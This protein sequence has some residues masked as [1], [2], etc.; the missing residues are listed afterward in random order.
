[1]KSDLGDE[2]NK[3]RRIDTLNQFVDNTNF[4]IEN[5]LKKIGFSQLQMLDFFKE[6]LDDDERINS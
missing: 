5:Y 6:I 2:G 1:L 4:D 3:D